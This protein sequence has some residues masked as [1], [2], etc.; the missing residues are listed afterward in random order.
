MRRAGEGSSKAQLSLSSLCEFWQ[1]L[2]R[3]ALILTVCLSP[4][5]TGSSRPPCGPVGCACHWLTLAAGSLAQHTL[6]VCWVTQLSGAPGSGCC[7]VLC[8]T[9]SC[10]TPALRKMCLSL[11]SIPGTSPAGVQQ[12][13]LHLLLQPSAGQLQ[14]QECESQCSWL[15]GQAALRAFTLLTK[16][17]SSTLFHYRKIKPFSS[18][19]HART[20]LNNILLSKL[21]WIPAHTGHAEPRQSLLAHGKWPKIFM[22]KYVCVDVFIFTSNYAAARH[23]TGLSSLCLQLIVSLTS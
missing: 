21:G 17:M 13:L 3:A 23:F 12:A 19:P 15:V 11:P 2:N 5:S 1:I 7:A 18:F 20:V 10:L 14:V 22:H 4:G 8:Y 16:Q 6:A 9:A